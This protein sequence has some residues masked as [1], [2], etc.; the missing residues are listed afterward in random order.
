[1][2]IKNECKLINYNIKLSLY[3]FNK[4]KKKKLQRHDF[5]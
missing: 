4:Y 1:M 3:I 2:E 5:F